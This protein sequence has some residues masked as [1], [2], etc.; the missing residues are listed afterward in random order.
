MAYR[1]N[2]D[3][4][5][6]TCDHKG[7]ELL[8]D[9]TARDLRYQKALSPIFRIAQITDAN[10]FAVFIRGIKLGIDLIEI[11]NVSDIEFTDDEIRNSAM[12][13]Y[14]GII[15]PAASKLLELFFGDDDDDEE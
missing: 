11:E 13:T 12:D 3:N 7:V 14:E 6:N 5:I 9:N 1:F 8:E 2:S 10:E 4:I 15:S